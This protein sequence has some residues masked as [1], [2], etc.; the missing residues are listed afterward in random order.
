MQGAGGIGGLLARTDASGSTFYHSDAGGNITAMTDSSG[1]VVDSYYKKETFTW[2][3]TPWE[4]LTNG[5]VSW[6]ETNNGSTNDGSSLYEP[7][8]ILSEH[9]NV[10]SILDY[11]F[12]QPRLFGGYQTGKVDTVFTR[13]AQTTWKLFTGGKSEVKKQSLFV[14]TGSATEMLERLYAGPST[15]SGPLTRPIASEKIEIGEL[16]TLDKDG[17]LYVVLPDGITKDATPCVDNLEYYEFAVGA[18]KHYIELVKPSGNPTNAPSGEDRLVYNASRPGVLTV[19]FIGRLTD[20]G[21]AWVLTNRVKFDADD[22]PGS[23]K[24][25][26]VAN[27]GGRP[28]ANGS[29]LT[30]TLYYTTLPENNSAFGLKFGRMTLD[31]AEVDQKCF[32]AFYD[33]DAYNWPG[34]GLPYDTENPYPGMQYTP[35]NY[36]YYYMQTAA[37]FGNPLFDYGSSHQTWPWQYCPPRH[38]KYYVEI[39]N[40]RSTSQ[41]ILSPGANAGQV[42]NYIDRFAWACRH[43]AR[44]SE[45]YIAW[46]GSQCYSQT[47]DVDVW[48]PPR[49]YGDAIPNWVEPT[50]PY[51][52]GEPYSPTNALTF[53]GRFDGTSDYVP[54]DF[55]DDQLYTCL[56]AQVWTTTQQ[57]NSFKVD[58][59]K[60]GKNWPEG[61]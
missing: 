32:W 4:E 5:I 35:P 50:L 38:D 23:T 44:H 53:A 31:G 25:W 16:G 18:N 43:E 21:P 36:H 58:W 48:D 19:T 56:T 11:G 33:A 27:P 39:R 60:P 15:N 57:T 37:G 6:H 34:C 41:P 54:G 30:A 52:A 20:Y 13:E 45:N 24:T 49:S 55:D 59:A 17:F 9:C 12:K 3:E 1:N 61:P 2:P 26:D 40:G 29:D 8:T 46:W 47:N 28:I 14:V 51:Y 42:L 10:R 22:I 7:P